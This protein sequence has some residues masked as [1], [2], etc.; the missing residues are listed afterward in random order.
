MKPP[1]K[2]KSE[3]TAG[4]NFALII[5][6]REGRGRAVACDTELTNRLPTYPHQHYGT[7]GSG[8][9]AVDSAADSVVARS[10]GCVGGLLDGSWLL[11][12]RGSTDCVIRVPVCARVSRVCPGSSGVFLP[13]RKLRGG[14]NTR[15]G[16][17]RQSAYRYPPVWPKSKKPIS[18]FSCRAWLDARRGQQGARMFTS[19]GSIFGTK[20]AAAHAHGRHEHGRSSSEAVLLLDCGGADFD[21]LDGAD[22]P[23][24]PVNS[25]LKIYTQFGD[26]LIGVLETG[27][28]AAVF[29]LTNHVRRS[30]AK[31]VCFYAQWLVAD[32]H[33]ADE[34][35]AIL[36]YVEWTAPPHSPRK[37]S[38]LKAADASAEDRS[39]TPPRARGN[40][41]EQ[42][43]RL[44]LRVFAT[45]AYAV[46][47]GHRIKVLPTRSQSEV[48]FGTVHRLLHKGTC[49]VRLD[50]NAGDLPVDPR[51][52]TVATA[53]HFHYSDGDLL[54][55][56]HENKPGNRVWAMV[57]VRKWMGFG[58]RY[59]V[60]ARLRDFEGE[61]AAKETEAI[62]RRLARAIESAAVAQEVELVLALIWTSVRDLQKMPGD[63]NDED[64]LS[65]AADVVVHIRKVEMQ[66]RAKEA[67][68]LAAKKASRTEVEEQAGMEMA[69]IDARLAHLNKNRA[70]ASTNDLLEMKKLKQEMKRL[71]DEEAER[72]AKWLREDAEEAAQEIIDGLVD[73]VCNSSGLPKIS[74]REHD[75]GSLPEHDP[76]LERVVPQ[77]W[78][79][80]VVLE[81]DLA[82]YNHSTLDVA[83]ESSVNQLPEAVIGLPSSA[84][85]AV[86]H[87]RR[88]SAH[89]VVR[90]S[91][92]ASPPEN[93]REA[94][95]HASLRHELAE[96]LNATL[97]FDLEGAVFEVI[98]GDV[99][100]VPACLSFPLTIAHSHTVI[101]TVLANKDGGTRFAE[102]VRFLASTWFKAAE[103]GVSTAGRGLLV[104]LRWAPDATSPR[105]TIT[106]R[107]GPTSSRAGRISMESAPSAR[108]QSAI[109]RITPNLYYAV[110]EG[111]RLAVRSTKRPSELSLGRVVRLLH[112]THGG[113][114][115]VEIDNGGGV[116]I[117]D[118]RPPT[119]QPASTPRYTVADHLM[120]LYDGEWRNAAVLEGDAEGLA[121]GSLHKLRMTILK[122]SKSKFT[123]E[124]T[125]EL[126]VAV[127][128][129]ECNHIA[130]PVMVAKE[131]EE[132]RILYIRSVLEATHLVEDNLTSNKVNIKDQLI[133]VALR[134]GPTWHS[135]CRTYARWTKL[136]SVRDL[137]ALLLAPSPNRAQGVI[138][139]LP[140]LISA[141][142]G[143]GKSWLIRQAAYLLAERLLEAAGEPPAVLGTGEP[144][145]APAPSPAPAALEPPPPPPLPAIP[146]GR[147]G[148]AH[149][150]S[151]DY[152]DLGK[153]I[154]GYQVIELLPSAMTLDE[155]PE[156]DAEAAAAVK[157]H[158]GLITMVGAA[159]A[160]KK[161]QVKSVVPTDEAGVWVMAPDA[162]PLEIPMERIWRVKCEGKWLPPDNLRF[163][164]DDGPIVLP[165]RTRPP[166]LEPEAAPAKDDL[167]APAVVADLTAAPSLLEPTPY[168]DI[169][170]ANVA[171]MVNV[172]KDVA[173]KASIVIGRNM[174]L[175]VDVSA[176]ASIITD[177]DEED[178]QYPQLL[179]QYL[180]L[181]YPGEEQSRTR[182]L[183]LQAYVMRELTILVDGLDEAA[184][185]R[186]HVE[187]WVLGTLLTSGNQLVVT[188]RP[189]GTEIARY[190]ERFIV[191]A[192]QP[193]TDEQ[194]WKVLDETTG[195]SVLF[196]HMRSICNTARLQDSV[197]LHNFPTREL[198]ARIESLEVADRFFLSGG[199]LN[200]GMRL[201][202]CDGMRLLAAH[203]GPPKSKYLLQIA[204]FLMPRVYKDPAEEAAEEAERT[205]MKNKNVNP[206]LRKK[207]AEK[208][209]ILQDL[210]NLLKSRES[211]EKSTNGAAEIEAVIRQRCGV[212]ASEGLEGDA[213][214]AYKLGVMTLRAR[215]KE[216]KLMAS[217]FWARVVAH[218]DELY[219]L[220][221][222][223]LPALRETLTLLLKEA[224][225]DLEP[226]TLQVQG[227]IQALW[228]KPPELGSKWKKIGPVRPTIGTEI[229]SE[230]LEEALR[231]KQE[232]S[233]KEISLFDVKDLKAD[234]FIKVDDQYFEQIDDKDALVIGRIRDPFEMH[235]DAVEMYGGYSSDVLPETLIRDALKA[236]I[237]CT[238]S[239]AMVKLCEILVKGFDTELAAGVAGNLRQMRIEAA[240]LT[241]RF[242]RLDPSH[243]RTM[244]FTGKLSAKL[245]ATEVSIYVDMQVNHT[246]VVKTR[247]LETSQEPYTYFRER[248]PG[249][250]LVNVTEEMER[251]FRFL[252]EATRIPVLFSMLVIICGA[253]SDS[254]KGL[255][256]SE[257]ELYQL[258][259]AAAARKLGNQDAAK[260]LISTLAIANQMAR[261][262]EI[263]TIE[264]GACLTETP[265]LQTL[266]NTLVKE[267]KPLPLLKL[268]AAKSAK[269]AAQYEFVH[270][271]IQEG[272]Y[273]ADLLRNVNTWVG[274]CDDVSAAK[275]LNEQFNQNVCRIGSTPLGEALAKRRANW[276]FENE[277]H[278]GLTAVGRKA[279]LPLLQ[280]NT[281]LRS[282]TLSGMIIDAT[283]GAVLG[284]CL[285]SMNSLTL[286][287]LQGTKMGV[288]AGLLAARLLGSSNGAQLTT[289]NLADTALGREGMAPLATALQSHK[290][291]KE[292]DISNNQLGPTGCTSLC[293]VL[294]V[295]RSLRTVVLLGEKLG[296]R[297]SE[298]LGR[299][300][301]ENRGSGIGFWRSDAIT[302]REE[303]IALNTT[304]LGAAEVSLVA[305]LL[306][307]NETLQTLTLT[308]SNIGRI[309]GRDA[310]RAL[311]AL[312]TG[313]RSNTGLTNIDLHGVEL[314]ESAKRMLGSSLLQN[315]GGRR[316][317]L[318]FSSESCPELGTLNV[319]DETSVTVVGLDAAAAI[320]LS[321]AICGHAS[322]TR[323]DVSVH[324]TS[325]DGGRDLGLSMASA[326]RGN[327]ILPLTHLVLN[328]SPIGED[329]MR[330]IGNALLD[331]STGK[332]AQAG[333][334]VAYLSCDA[335]SVNE[336]DV[337][338]DLSTHTL[339]VGAAVLLAGVLKY[340][341]RVTTLQVEKSKRTGNPPLPVQYLKGAE[342][343]HEGFEPG[344]FSIKALGVVT[345]TLIGGLVSTNTMFTKLR[346]QSNESA[347]SNRSL[348][349]LLSV[350]RIN[351]ESAISSLDLA[352]YGLDEKGAQALVVALQAGKLPKLSNLDISNH[353]LDLTSSDSM[354]SVLGIAS[355]LNIAQPVSKIS[356]GVQERGY[357]SSVVKELR[358]TGKCVV[359]AAFV[360][361]RDCDWQSNVV[362]S[363]DQPMQFILRCLTVQEEG[364]PPVRIG[365]G[366][367]NGSHQ[368][369]T[370][371][372]EECTIR[373]GWVLDDF[374]VHFTSPSKPGAWRL[375]IWAAYGEDGPS[376]YVTSSPLHII[377]SGVGATKAE[378]APATAPEVDE[379]AKTEVSDPTTA[380]SEPI[381]I[382]KDDCGLIDGDDGAQT[383]KPLLR[384][385]TE[386][387]VVMPPPLPLLEDCEDK[388]EY[389]SKVQ[390]E[391][392]ERLLQG[393]DPW[394][395]L[396]MRRS[397]PAVEAASDRVRKA[398]WVAAQEVK[399]VRKDLGEKRLQVAS[400]HEQIV[401]QRQ[402]VIR[403]AAVM[404]HQSVEQRRL[405][406][407]EA[408]FKVKMDVISWQERKGVEQ[409]AWIENIKVRVKEVTSARSARSARHAEEQAF[410]V[411]M[412]VIS[413][414]DRALK[415]PQIETED[416]V[417]YH[418]L[419]R[420]VSPERERS[421]PRV[422]SPPTHSPPPPAACDPT[423]PATPRLAA[424]RK[425][426]T[427]A[428]KKK[429]AAAGRAAAKRVNSKKKEQRRA[430]IGAFSTMLNNYTIEDIV[431]NA[432]VVVQAVSDT[433]PHVRIA[434]RA[435]LDRFLGA[436]GKLKVHPLLMP[437][438]DGLVDSL[439]KKMI[440]PAAETRQSV[441]DVLALMHKECLARHAPSVIAQLKHSDGEVRLT[442]IKIL[443][444]L[445]P[446]D[447]G[448]CA[449]TLS[450]MLDDRSTDVRRAV[451]RAMAS[452]E[453]STISGYAERIVSTL[454]NPDVS[455]RRL[456]LTTVFGQ[457][458]AP[459]LEPYQPVI[460]KYL[461]GA[462]AAELRDAVWLLSTMPTLMIAQFAKSLVRNLEDSD[463]AVS[464][465]AQTA[466]CK[467][468][469]ATLA[470][471]AT[472]FTDRLASADWK[473]C[474]SGLRALAKLTP[475]LQQSAPLIF[476]RLDDDDVNVRCAVLETMRMMKPAIILSKMSSVVPMLLDP[477]DHVRT[478][479]IDLI[480]LIDP[481]ELVAQT[482]SLPP[483]IISCIRF[484]DDRVRALA[485][486]MA[487]HYL[488]YDQKLVRQYAELG[489]FVQLLQDPSAQVRLAAIPTAARFEKQ[490]F[491]AYADG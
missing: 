58:N 454:S 219:V 455:Y 66:Q 280:N 339:S 42:P 403:T 356:M 490:D 472:D 282:V 11:D 129:N 119:V 254:L 329:G 338:L 206:N 210:D 404:A 32:E 407:L 401:K 106:A 343:N 236:K 126:N 212:D 102:R 363:M 411:R 420:E 105:G 431:G 160:R 144:A 20:S 54:L 265:E 315:Q 252:V 24:L 257:L 36:A 330:A 65:T 70:R 452:L 225:V 277:M 245:P 78:V 296:L 398:K 216:P 274:W 481:T 149:A 352:D 97:L 203:N 466:L 486:T 86:V 9:A 273:A 148:W 138:E 69:A 371:P 327:A 130:N 366:W 453:A 238:D 40:L 93:S 477:N 137:T 29:E 365:M 382:R 74:L 41:D 326:I 223:L 324:P 55:V 96:G 465:A 52:S 57:R 392:P 268:V 111:V 224:G 478:T 390:A 306:K 258:A 114:C 475:I 397:S 416:E 361:I 285:R 262:R 189:E 5:E 227:G 355:H 380:A 443:S 205:R 405:K 202:T 375:H 408:G 251:I 491:I 424:A 232:F 310:S 427:E 198:R 269:Q 287:N 109:I 300:L 304:D 246:A 30:F 463:E 292:L 317:A 140:V 430:E 229:F 123:A 214:G 368:L 447:L 370:H 87:G 309:G 231:V 2:T 415:P 122:P 360:E 357:P 13:G 388:Q 79:N 264:V 107:G 12:V 167:M 31:S 211:L 426:R 261:R 38:A 209:E 234:S 480:N 291:I 117:V 110:N 175:I 266:W 145:P 14:V 139:V 17:M 247:Q 180:E 99:S 118:P 213:W 425:A 197:Y 456:M 80:D 131:Y 22:V 226:R 28:G 1:R 64:Q 187:T 67:A 136:A 289:L 244:R 469:P 101:G 39:I 383:T 172:L 270:L 115:V 134:D 151:V 83:L 379:S 147:G 482:A 154:S 75:L 349:A 487:G 4:A 60:V 440:D 169:D 439:V 194:R 395:M 414:Q 429:D 364:T 299:A 406:N 362:L 302:I 328:R 47:P 313:L 437:D 228:S 241:N 322:L 378:G 94:E 230:Q 267:E 462:S 56:P 185:L 434:A 275:F 153:E 159:G 259:T 192:L 7:F 279:L 6:S 73:A 263:S 103:H 467:L 444:L 112:G 354:S 34:T 348:E 476:R 72:A 394:N 345:A 222:L 445:D 196:G 77:I 419:I 71:Q 377:V 62:E 35:G 53:A 190:K 376:S 308:N 421:Q 89:H 351:K 3:R 90:A 284:E 116:L 442:G 176:L 332:A 281:I 173:P 240:Q 33:G 474:V 399:V 68:E 170:V 26:T 183:L 276:H 44:A 479:V 305:G 150:G 141:P 152:K 433:D 81:V 108:M 155:L 483:Q 121:Q 381:H 61:M 271:S 471:H 179:Q 16:A 255:P 25:Y 46:A 409:R 184:G 422:L 200:S 218:T 295:N 470:S 91:L 358:L 449:T 215:K 181:K 461:S 323:L 178:T 286:L 446:K 15:G 458:P 396:Q 389:E 239:T 468:D 485:I 340:N 350:L 312:A 333:C 63:W 193:L 393:V 19:R 484:P 142:S 342:I 21:V 182:Q 133:C 195:K 385:N 448:H 457:I 174:P 441:V 104:R 272:L 165:P 293:D 48:R 143:S 335:F 98:E 301:L 37:L 451:A 171:G 473:E 95:Q 400:M 359:D 318:R 177:E 321:G 316:A 191:V 464:V 156:D 249:S 233:K 164:R 319:F 417:L 294:R 303:T 297:T 186:E 344:V 124:T 432:A 166:E 325:R 168:S 237:F 27:E 488:D 146:D 250:S 369:K 76:R 248:L 43:Y 391:R 162:K 290:Q 412:D 438:M 386:A 49:I 10:C 353:R 460:G 341:S 18:P 278:S 157:L 243:N 320:L 298:N 132:Q 288:I 418:S 256:S 84:P 402:L 331:G 125:T 23:A 311:R 334:R 208:P 283:E 88:P 217:T 128:L 373:G 220:C 82:E 347:S 260:D 135:S 337:T 450:L 346:V 188:T 207:P 253:D 235:S 372:S 100:T 45:L 204:R 59:V 384:K 410:K 163:L 435:A 428:A 221:E 387:P 161:L 423:A 113:K 85:N 158:L 489:D 92:G 8:A 51:P 50:Q 242:D 459:A 199:N 413:F 314:G 336:D 127:D 307:H 120:V 436:A 367:S 201:K 374:F